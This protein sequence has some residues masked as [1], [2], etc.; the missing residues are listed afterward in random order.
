MTKKPRNKSAATQALEQI[1]AKS[2][3]GIPWLRELHRKHQMPL[4]LRAAL[5]WLENRPAPGTDDP[6]ADDSVAALRRERIRLTA[7][8]AERAEHL[9]AAQRKEY[10][11]KEY[12]E[13]CA[14]R[15]GSA[16]DCAFKAF[17]RAVP[18]ALQ[19]LKM[20]QARERMRIE[21]NKMRLLLADD[22]SSLWKDMAD[23]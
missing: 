14:K 1:A 4:E 12:H 18:T 22:Q 16:M 7:A 23:E 5:Q 6:S 21:V 8:Q 9:L 13:D 15:I 2:G 19:G 10:V 17:E 11:S 3:L 20:P